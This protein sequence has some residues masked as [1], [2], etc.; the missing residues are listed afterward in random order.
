MT[1]F[2]GFGFSD[3]GSAA[4]WALFGSDIG[5]SLLSF[6]TITGSPSLAN[7]AGKVIAEWLVNLTRE[8]DKMQEAIES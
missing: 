6:A 8:I 3:Y 4:F 2:Y 7:Y 1:L 5:I